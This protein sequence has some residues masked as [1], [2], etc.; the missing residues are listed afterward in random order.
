MRQKLEE[1]K[2]TPLLLVHV[3]KNILF[4]LKTSFYLLG[5]EMSV[6]LNSADAPHDS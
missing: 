5:V 6:Y 3:V 2:G 4:L 1:I